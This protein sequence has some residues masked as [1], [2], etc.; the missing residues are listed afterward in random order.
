MEVLGTTLFFFVLPMVHGIH[1]EF[2]H[3]FEE[4]ITF[5]ILVPPSTYLTNPKPKMGIHQ[6]TGC[7]KALSMK[8]NEKKFVLIDIFLSFLPPKL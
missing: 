2:N 5:L 1:Y 3:I 6:D 8:R 4:R 7:Q